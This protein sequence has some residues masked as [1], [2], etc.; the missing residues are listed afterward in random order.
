[1]AGVLSLIRYFENSTKVKISVL[2]IFLTGLGLFVVPDFAL[3]A[4]AD[5][6]TEKSKS[7]GKYFK[8]K[9]AISEFLDKV[10]LDLSEGETSNA[11]DRIAK[12]WIMPMSEFQTIRSKVMRQKTMMR[13]RFGKPIGYEFVDSTMLAESLKH[14]VYILKHEKHIT[15]WHFYFYKPKDKWLMNTFYFNDQIR[16]LFAQF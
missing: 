9:T 3:G 12:K 15:Q 10:M 14:Y 8:D 5:T 11:F 16:S 4:S 13:K 1:M 6:V 2:A 7:E